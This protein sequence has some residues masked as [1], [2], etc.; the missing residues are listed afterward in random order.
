MPA[1]AAAEGVA[2]GPGA[3]VGCGGAGARGFDWLLALGIEDDEAA[4]TVAGR[5]S[6]QAGPAE[7]QVEQAALAGVH[8]REGVGAARGADTFDGG[9]GDHLKLAVAEKLEIFCVEGDA[10]VLL[11]FKAED[12]GGEVLDGMEEFS[13]AGEQE[14]SI[15]AGEFDGDLGGWRGGL[16][17]AGEDFVLQ[18]QAAG[19]EQSLE[20]L[21]NLFDLLVGRAWVV[22]GS[23]LLLC[24]ELSSHGGGV[25]SNLLVAK[26]G[27][28]LIAVRLR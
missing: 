3:V 13:V 16:R 18:F 1:S 15:G 12:L 6:G 20:E 5:C 25:V 17:V 27:L 10:V 14:R 19:G 22:D 11:R 24:P 9:F 4:G 28:P 2:D 21:F 23:H 8:R 26:R 7:G